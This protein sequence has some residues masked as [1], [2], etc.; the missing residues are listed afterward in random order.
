MARRHL[1][2]YLDAD[3]FASL[4]AVANQNG[5]TLTEAICGCIQRSCLQL[6]SGHSVLGF[7]AVTTS[8]EVWLP[9]V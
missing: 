4:S 3:D 8:G 5:W 2:F 9:K 1:N 6:L 7:K